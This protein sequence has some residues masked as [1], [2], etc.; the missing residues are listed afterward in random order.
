MSKILLGDIEDYSIGKKVKVLYDSPPSFEFYYKAG[1]EGIISDIS[2]NY[3]LVSFS[4]GKRKGLTHYLS[5]T[6]L[7]LIID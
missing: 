4:S 7:G 3:I 2:D 5:Y 6:E 1:D